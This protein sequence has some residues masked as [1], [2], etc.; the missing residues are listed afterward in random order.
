V[1]ACEDADFESIIWEGKSKSG[2]RKYRTSL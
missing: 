1:F 2:F